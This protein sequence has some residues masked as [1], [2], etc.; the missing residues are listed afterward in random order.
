MPIDENEFFRQATLEI[1]GSLDMKT[2]MR[3]CLGYLE[4]VMPVSRISLHIYEIG[5]GAIRTILLA[6]RDEGKEVDILSPLTPEMRD[7]LEKQGYTDGL[8]VIERLR[9]DPVMVRIVNSAE[10][11]SITGL[12]S[13]Q[14]RP[15]TDASV[16]AMSLRS[17]GSHLGVVVCGVDG[18]GVY[19][20]E[21]AKLFS[22]LH[23][24]FAIALSNALKHQEVLRL[25]DI[26]ADD[27]RYL[28]RELF[29]LSGDEI[30][31]SRSGLKGVMDMAAKVAD[32][33]NALLLLGETGAGKD[34]VAHSIH[35]SSPRKDGP[36]IKVNCGAIP[37]TLIDSELFGHEKGAFTGA[38]AQNRGCFERA[39]RGTIFLDEIGELPPAAQVRMLR[40]IQ[41]REI[42]RVGGCGPIP[43]DIRIIAATHRNLEEMVKAGKFRE[44]LW[45]RLNVFPIVIPSLRERKS[46]IPALVSHFMGKK[47]KELKLAGPPALARG[48]IDQLMEYDWPGN[49]RE[50][51]NVIERALILSGN[52][53]LTFAPFLSPGERK[54]SIPPAAGEQIGPL[55]GAVSGYIRRAL[56]AAKGRIHGPGGAAELLDMKPSTLR[57]KMK[58]LHIPFKYSR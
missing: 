2:A 21:H 5:L 56:E 48:A 29:R 23:D 45:F 17:D 19:S 30:I 22:L 33:D 9:G 37:E 50:L 14:F 4:R 16:L 8:L 54:G 13:R 43:V 36:F 34:V 52:G 7:R 39:D 6:T 12:V 1:C 57:S 15:P 27:N 49:V 58:K 32:L 38:T 25:K 11:D 40:V 18:K 24:P 44:D 31:G 10:G 41:Y 35:F 42:Q 46:D 47:S 20:E 26:L 28:H 51:E 53:P 55:D 3:R